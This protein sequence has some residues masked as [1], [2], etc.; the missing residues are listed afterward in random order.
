M[1]QKAPTALFPKLVI[2]RGTLSSEA[3]GHWQVHD[4]GVAF[5]FEAPDTRWR[6]KSPAPGNA[7]CIK[8]GCSLERRGFALRR[9]PGA[10]ARTEAAG[11]AT[12]SAN[13]PGARARARLADAGPSTGRAA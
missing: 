4:T 6:F 10:S 1:I 13:V 5:R 9:G 2:N 7:A 8:A 11:N 12:A 3:K